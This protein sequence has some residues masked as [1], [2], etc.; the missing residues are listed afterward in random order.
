MED[1]RTSESLRVQRGVKEELITDGEVRG[2]FNY[3]YLLR[4]SC[5]RLF[6]RCQEHKSEQG[7][8]PVFE[9][10]TLYQEKRGSGCALERPLGLPC[11]MGQDHVWDT[12]RL[13]QATIRE[14]NLEQW[15]Q[16]QG[17]V[18]TQKILRLQN[19][20]DKINDWIQE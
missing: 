9:A 7:T 17:E 5:Y 14:M 6:A 12:G 15:Q 19:G 16:R 4:T 10:L 20:Q 18:D 11:G 8:R 3:M 13:T 1:F 2:T